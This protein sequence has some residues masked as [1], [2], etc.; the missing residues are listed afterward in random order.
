MKMKKEDDIEEILKAYDLDYLEWQDY[1][2]SHYPDL[3]DSYKS[4][5]QQIEN[6]EEYTKELDDK[7]MEIAERLADANAEFIA[8]QLEKQYPSMEFEVLKG[9]TK[10]KRKKKPK[11][12]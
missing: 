2:D 4:I 12:A 5:N 11:W 1:I 10:N 3:L 6:C 8:K 9:K 7:W